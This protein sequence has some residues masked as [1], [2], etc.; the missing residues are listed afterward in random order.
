MKSYTAFL[1]PKSNVPLLGD[2]YKNKKNLKKSIFV[3]PIVF[4]LRQI[5]TKGILY[6]D[7]EGTKR[8][9]RLFMMRR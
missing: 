9:E 3:K 4:L 7:F 1:I 6:S 2:E 8:V 5:D